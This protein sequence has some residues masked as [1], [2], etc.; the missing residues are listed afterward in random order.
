[1]SGKPNSCEIYGLVRGS[2]FLWKWRCRDAGGREQVCPQE[3]KRFAECA[4]AARASGYEPRSDWTG[5][6]AL[7]STWPGQ[8]GR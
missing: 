5:P 4:A 3:Y 7:V 1:M 2:A 8:A 6:C